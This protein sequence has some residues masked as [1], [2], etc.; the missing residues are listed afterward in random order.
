MAL[1]DGHE[2]PQRKAGMPCWAGSQVHLSRCGE[3]ARPGSTVLTRLP[4][5]HFKVALEH[6]KVPQSAPLAG[7]V[8]HQAFM[9]A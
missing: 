4:W 7:H 2:W 5:K 3:V 8:L 6:N 9:R 1:N